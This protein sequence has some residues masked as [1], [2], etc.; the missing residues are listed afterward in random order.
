MIVINAVDKCCDY[1]NLYTNADKSVTLAGIAGVGLALF[2]LRYIQVNTLWVHREI[3]L[4][5]CP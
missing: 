3:P 5:G 1:R 2:Q 4:G